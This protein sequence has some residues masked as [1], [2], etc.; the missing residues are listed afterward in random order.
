MKGQF[1]TVIGPFEFE[2]ANYPSLGIVVLLDNVTA[3]ALFFIIIEGQC[4]T[5]LQCD[6]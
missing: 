5:Y 1:E 6:G 2:N 3:L 4:S